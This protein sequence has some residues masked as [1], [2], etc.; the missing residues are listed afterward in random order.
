M[1]KNNVFCNEC[2]NLTFVIMTDVKTVIVGCI[3]KHE[4]SVILSKWWLWF[5]IMCCILLLFVYLLLF[6][7]TNQ[8]SVT[9]RLVTF[10]PVRQKATVNLKGMAWG[11]EPL[12]Q[13]SGSMV[14]GSLQKVPVAWHIKSPVCPGSQCCVMTVLLEV[15][16]IY[17][18]L[19]RCIS[20]WFLQLLTVPLL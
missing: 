14:Y 10:I 7:W 15:I 4:I 3:Y 20:Y 1:D 13:V 8:F 9:L 5:L 19:S 12:W 11:H 6:T 18:G 17:F 16:H 2:T